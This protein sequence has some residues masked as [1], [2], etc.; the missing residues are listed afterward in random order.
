MRRR[1]RRQQGGRG[2]RK[3]QLGSPHI[4]SI[5]SHTHQDAWGDN[6]TPWGP[7]QTGPSRMLNTIESVRRQQGGRGRR[8]YQNGSHAH[9]VTTHGTMSANRLQHT[10]P[11]GGPVYYNDD[12]SQMNYQLDFDVEGNP[13]A[14]Y[15]AA[16]WQDNF[17]NAGNETQHGYTGDAYGENSGPHSHNGG[18]GGLGPPRRN[19]RLTNIQRQRGGRIRRQMGGNGGLPN[20]WGK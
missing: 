19:P 17:W 13:Y 5:P 16:G 4:H 9:Q 15:W 6:V 1:V 14:Q 18:N 8:R 7:S 2:R 11:P 10:H 20:P 12:G 3:F